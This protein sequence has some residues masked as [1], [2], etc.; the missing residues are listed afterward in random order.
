MRDGGGGEEARRRRAWPSS[1][2]PSLRSRAS[3]RPSSFFRLS[4]LVF[5]CL[6]LSG[7]LL[8]SG[9]QP[10]EDVAP[11]GGNLSNSFVSAEGSELRT[12]DIGGD[13]REVQVIA[14]VS[15]EMGDLNV[16][17][18]KPDGSVVFT[19]GS[20]P[21]EQ[22]TRSGRVPLDDQGRLNYQ[23]HAVGARNGSYQILFQS[24]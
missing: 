9:A 12:L 15:V 8:M 10:S 21:G 20:K 5:A 11:G 13:V 4:S 6:A 3:F 19:V 1:F 22:V 23:I 18:L 14:I 17:L 16:D 24:T 7:C 2:V